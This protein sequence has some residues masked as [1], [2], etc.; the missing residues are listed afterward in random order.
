MQSVVLHMARPS[1]LEMRV[2][3]VLDGGRLR[4]SSRVRVSAMAMA[5]TLLA[6]GIGL[7]R[8]ADAGKA[9]VGTVSLTAAQEAARSAAAA[10][11][12]QNAQKQAEILL[13]LANISAAMA[14]A[15]QIPTGPGPLAAKRY[16]FPFSGKSAGGSQ[17]GGDRRLRVADAGDAQTNR[18]ASGR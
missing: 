18:T 13:E 3:G 7:L 17:E 12:L 1:T 9:P 6:A 8:A 5:V 10:D 11:M 2:R 15:S 4:H 16:L 14:N